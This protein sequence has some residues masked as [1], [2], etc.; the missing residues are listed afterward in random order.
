MHKS[1]TVPVASAIP[2]CVFCGIISCACANG[3]DG[4]CGGRL[5][6]IEADLTQ[7][8][9]G[10]AGHVSARNDPLHDLP[11]AMTQINDL[12]TWRKTFFLY[13]WRLPDRKFFRLS[14]LNQISTASVQIAATFGHSGF[15]FVVC[16]VGDSG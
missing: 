15:C 8:N 2:F 4:R 7:V 16:G 13:P 5:E 9:L 6:V 3:M 11:L 12:K 14:F 10:R 1:R